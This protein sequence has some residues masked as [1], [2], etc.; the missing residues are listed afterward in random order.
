MQQ[1]DPRRQTGGRRSRGIA[2]EGTPTQ[3]L[4]TIITAVFNG[5]AFL[6]ECIESVLAQDYPHIE[7]VILDG[8]SKDGTLE[9]LRR[10]DDRIALWIREPDRG[11][12]DAWNK[13]LEL[14]RG[15]WIAFLGSDDEYLPGAV[16]AYMNLAAQHP[17][18][19]YL[20][21][22]IR[23]QHPAGYSRQQ[24]EPWS[25]P[26]YCRYMCSVH[27]GSMHRRRLFDNY[28]VF[29]LSYRITADYE[30]LL[31]PRG[32]LR[33]AFLPEVT[34]MMRAGGVSDSIAALHEASRAKITTGGRSRWIA[35][36]E[37]ALALTKYRIRTLLNRLLL[38][39]KGNRAP[40]RSAS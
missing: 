6:A 15:E 19:D 36:P 40:I 1:D 7:H 21:S 31:R 2:V 35:L 8:G 25:W 20:S 22:Y 29:D 30:F 38:A 34:I 18:A 3:P 24:G 17:E 32:E 26:L 12:Y 37:L 39:F 16:T 13:G 5:E 11:V 10:Y 33:A 14:A 27:V 4:V 23:W 28:G 9:I